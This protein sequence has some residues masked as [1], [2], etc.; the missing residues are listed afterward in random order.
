VHSFEIDAPGHS[1]LLVLLSPLPLCTPV[2]ALLLLLLLLFAGL[3]SGSGIMGWGMHIICRKV[4]G[5]AQGCRVN[6]E[7]NATSSDRLQTMTHALTKQI[8]YAILLV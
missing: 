6:C 1:K 2:F 4:A 3:G 8:Y 7:C 5:K